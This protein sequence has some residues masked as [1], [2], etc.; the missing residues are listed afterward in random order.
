MS[1]R[2]P[3]S[4]A[5]RRAFWPSLP[6]ASESWKSGTI[7]SAIPVSSWSRTSRTLAGASARITNSGA[8]ELNGHDVDL[9]AAQLVDDLAHTHAPRADARADRVDVLVVRR[10]R[11][12]GPVSGLARDRADLD[13]TVDELRYLEFEEAAHETGVRARNDDLRALGRLAHLDDVGL[14]A[15]AVVVAVARD[16]LGLWQQ[17]LHP[18]QVEQGVAGVGLL[19]DA[20]DDVALAA[21][22]LLV[23]HLALG[24]ADPLQ[25][26]L[27][28]G[29]RGDAPEVGGR[30][31]PLPRDV[32]LFVELLG[33]HPDL[34]GLDVDLDE[35]LLGGLGHALVRGDERVG[36]RLE[37]DLLGDPLL[38][39]QRRKRFEHLG[40]FT[41]SPP[42]SHHC[43]CPRRRAPASSSRAR[44]RPIRRRCAPG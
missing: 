26:H 21:R 10:D 24:L 12:L 5:A 42:S 8:S 19:D 16:L 28:G 25:D 13:D 20:G 1:T 14:H 39:G 33:D 27:L 44:A 15:R 4:R 18:A 36:E 31:V 11:D 23:L 37:H 43:R 2:Q 29:L 40:I 32:A 35:R 17:R 22:V 41:P 6:I 7:T 30:V 34:A 38:D 3:V 9:L